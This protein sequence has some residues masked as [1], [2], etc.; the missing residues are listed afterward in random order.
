MNE[1]SSRTHRNKA[2]GALL[3]GCLM[4]AV[5][6][7]FF[8]LMGMRMVDDYQFRNQTILSKG[9]VLRTKPKPHPNYPGDQRLIVEYFDGV[10][11][12]RKGIPCSDCKVSGEWLCCAAVGD[13]VMMRHF[14]QS[15][16]PE[17]VMSPW[18]VIRSDDGRNAEYRDVLSGVFLAVFFFVGGLFIVVVAIR[19]LRRKVTH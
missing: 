8:W 11:K 9:V 17:H 19:A 10:K 13:T 14:D 18:R 15:N 3:I 1:L 7:W 4:L 5:A 6:C 12:R 2:K 16:L